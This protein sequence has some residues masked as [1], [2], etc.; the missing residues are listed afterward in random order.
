MNEKIIIGGDLNG[1]VGQDLEGIERWHGGW[2]VGERNPEGQR[3]LNFMIS[4]DLALLNAFKKDRN[5]LTTYKS[6][7]REIQIGFL[8]CKRNNIKET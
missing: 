4:Q 1:H 2:N 6:G 8:A 5:Q 3:I 7:G